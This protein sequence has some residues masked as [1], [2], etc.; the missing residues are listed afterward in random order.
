MK[1]KVNMY[2]IISIENSYLTLQQIFRKIT[3]SWIDK[4]NHWKNLT[5]LSFS[6]DIK[7][8]NEVF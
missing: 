5:N 7:V 4:Y 6:E 1:V 2:F 8:R 3:I